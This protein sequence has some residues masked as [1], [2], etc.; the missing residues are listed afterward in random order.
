[1]VNLAKQVAKWIGISLTKKKFAELV[2]RAIPF[3]GGVVAGG[4]TW[5]VFGASAKRLRSHL[6]GLPMAA[7]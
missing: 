4:M 5:A 6:A 1:M 7:C 2:G 3:L